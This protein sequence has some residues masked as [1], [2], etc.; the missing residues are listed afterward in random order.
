MLTFA[1]SQRLTQEQTAI[2]QIATRTEHQPIWIIWICLPWAFVPYGPDSLETRFY[3]KPSFTWCFL[4]EQWLKERG[5]SCSHVG[6]HKYSLRPPQAPEGK[7]CQ[8]NSML[9]SAKPT[10][11]LQEHCT[12]GLGN[13]PFFCFHAWPDPSYSIS[14]F[15]HIVAQSSRSTMFTITIECQP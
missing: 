12:I 2:L 4:G 10:W 13:S 14:I 8:G 6:P 5:A 1:N 7:V 15:R 11:C 9:N 3:R